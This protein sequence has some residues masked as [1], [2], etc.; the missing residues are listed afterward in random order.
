MNDCEH[1]FAYQGPVTWPSEHPLPGT[2]AHARYYGDAYFCERCL[3]LHVRNERVLGTTYEKVRG[4]AVE[5]DRKP[6]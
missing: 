2:G 5:Y 6:K 3:T 4:E 1:R